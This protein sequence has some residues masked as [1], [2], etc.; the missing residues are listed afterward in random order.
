MVLK[1]PIDLEISTSFLVLDF[2]D[3]NVSIDY[4]DP[5][6]KDNFIFSNIKNYEHDLEKKDSSYF[7]LNSKFEKYQEKEYDYL[8]MLLSF[9]I[10][11]GKY[12]Q[13]IK[14]IHNSLKRKNSNTNLLKHLGCDYVINPSRPI[15]MKINYVNKK[16]NENQRNVIQNSISTNFFYFIHGPSGTGKFTILSEISRQLSF[17]NKKI[18]YLAPTK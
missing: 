15:K 2:F 8:I 12:L 6:V 17:K 7:S 16:L 18:L 5:Y 9:N 13:K 11:I 10:N 3:R 4:Y 1:I 14:N